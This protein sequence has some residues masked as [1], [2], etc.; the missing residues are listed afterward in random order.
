MDF[1]AGIDKKL[2]LLVSGDEAASALVPITVAVAAVFL[3]LLYSCRQRGDAKI[4]GEAEEEED[5]PKKRT[6]PPEDVDP[7]R[8]WTAKE[9]AKY[10]GLEKPMYYV[11]C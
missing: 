3:G 10:D 2:S 6:F 5:V 11:R 9:L 4:M 1:I 8:V 7:E